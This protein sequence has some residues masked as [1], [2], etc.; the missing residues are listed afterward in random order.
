MAMAIPPGPGRRRLV[1]FSVSSWYFFGYPLNSATALLD[2]VLPSRCCA[3]WFVGKVLTWRLPPCGSVAGLLTEGGELVLFGLPLAMEVS[4]CDHAGSHPPHG[5]G[6]VGLGG[7]GVGK[8][9][10]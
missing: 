5:A 7:G 6:L 10:D 2:G 1:P 4:A 3:V 8:E 9:S